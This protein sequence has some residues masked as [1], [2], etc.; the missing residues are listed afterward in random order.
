MIL[1]L[2]AALLLGVLSGTL[3][4]LAPGI[5]INLVA[6][7][8]LSS[9]GSLTEIPI[10][11]LAIFIVSMSI[12]HTFLDFIPSIFL[13]APEEDTFLSI[14]PGHEMF[15]EGHGFQATVI[16]LY[17]SL[18]ALPIIILFSPLFI[19]F[20]PF[21][22]E[23]IKFLIPF[24]LIFLSLYLIFREDNFILSL[25]VFILAGF[26]GLATFNLPLKEP[27]L[28]LLSGLFGISSLIISLKNH[29]EPK[30]QSLTPLKEIKLSKAEFKR[31]S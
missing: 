9:L 18:A 23:T 17:G 26:L 15:K 29:N 14:L 22:Y 28:P 10:I 2:I 31:A 24:I 30:P 25:T 13:G 5:H 3:T 21:F 27:L 1:A 12:T 16:T 19:L 11:A 20:L 6:A 7:I 4:G 8:L